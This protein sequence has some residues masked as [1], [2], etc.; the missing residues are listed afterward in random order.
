MKQLRNFILWCLVVVLLAVLFMVILGCCSLR[1]EV[2]LMPISNFNVTR[3]FGQWYEIARFDH[4]FERGMTHTKARYTMHEDGYIQVINTG[5][6]DGK[7]KISIGKGQLTNQKG[8]LKVSF[9]WPF[10]GDY[11][12]LCIDENYQYALVG[13]DNADYLWILSRKS[14][15][16]VITK[17]AILLEAKRRGYDINKLIW[18]KR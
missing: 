3:Y 1:Q 18:V 10:Y 5:L 4:W 17:S 6:K 14:T 13:G 12:I 11:R 15:L 8:L 2:D 7:E 9:F 16:D